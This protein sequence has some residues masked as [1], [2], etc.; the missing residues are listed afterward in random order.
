MGWPGV[1]LNEVE[2]VAKVMHNS[3][4]EISNTSNSYNRRPSFLSF[5]L[6]ICLWVSTNLEFFY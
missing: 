5:S 2:S 1:G 3:K 4:A 6:R